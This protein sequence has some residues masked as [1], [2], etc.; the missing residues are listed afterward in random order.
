[1]RIDLADDEVG[2]EE[3]TPEE[4]RSLSK[5]DKDGIECILRDILTI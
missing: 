5:D 2:V 1:M 4:G 3:T